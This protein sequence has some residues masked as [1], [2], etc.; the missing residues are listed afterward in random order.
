MNIVQV[1]GIIIASRSYL[2]EA[3]EDILGMEEGELKLVLSGLSSLM[4]G[5]GEPSLRTCFV[6]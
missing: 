1:L 3:I 4:D 5:N 2:P 6:S